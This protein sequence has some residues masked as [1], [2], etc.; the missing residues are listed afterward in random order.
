MKRKNLKII[1]YLIII[2]ASGVILTGCTIGKT[3][4]WTLTTYNSST[5]SKSTQTTYPYT[6][7]PTKEDCRQA[8][9]EKTNSYQT[10]DCGLNC[11]FNEDFDQYVCEQVCIKSNKTGEL[12]CHE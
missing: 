8:G 2:I 5:R 10:F 12:I 6:I 7:Y 1:P 3:Q 4:E 11:Y 9:L